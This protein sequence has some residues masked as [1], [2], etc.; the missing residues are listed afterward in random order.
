MLYRHI[1]YFYLQ[2]PTAH[3]SV[4]PPCADAPPRPFPHRQPSCNCGSLGKERSS[5]K[6][7]RAHPSRD[8]RCGPPPAAGHQS[9]SGRADPAVD[10]PGSRTAPRC[11]EAPRDGPLDSAPAARP[12]PADAPDPGPTPPTPPLAD[13]TPGTQ[14]PTR[15]VPAASSAR[16]ARAIDEGPPV[17]PARRIP[18]PG[19]SPTTGPSPAAPRP[20]PI[21]G[22]PSP[23]PGPAPHAERT[24]SP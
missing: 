17:R 24:P 7:G 12:S 14:P 18:V 8:H 20:S 1:T 3:A 16:T 19:F 22:G 4:A 21:P 5:P 10:T 6:D 15:P 23:P 2:R 11:G 13:T 9:G